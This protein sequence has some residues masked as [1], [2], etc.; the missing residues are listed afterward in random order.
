MP[1]TLKHLNEI[2]VDIGVDWRRLL[3]TLDPEMDKYIEI[4]NEDNSYAL[5]RCYQG[6]KQW[7]EKAAS[8]ATVG[9]LARAL[10]A[11]KKPEIAVKLLEGALPT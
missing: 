8:R 5:E 6:L 9:K 4:I 10:C 1:V 2:C 11:I 3:R 7:M